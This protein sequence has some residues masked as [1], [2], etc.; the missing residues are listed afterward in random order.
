[1][2]TKPRTP[3]TKICSALTGDYWF[4]GGKDDPKIALLGL[5]PENAEVWIDAS[6]I[7]AGV[8]LLLGVDPK[9][10]FKD[11]VANVPLR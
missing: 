9:S 1:M 5:D 11:R 10:S 7:M 4:E 3:K 8:K 6:S 2:P